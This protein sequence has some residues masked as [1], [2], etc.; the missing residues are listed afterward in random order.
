MKNPL[1]NGNNGRDEKGRFA[2]G[3]KKG[4][5]NPYALRTAQMRRAMLNAVSDEDLHEIVTNLISQAKQGDTQAFNV[6]FDRLF[7]KPIPAT[8]LDRVFLEESTLARM[9]R[10]GAPTNTEHLVE[11]MDFKIPAPAGKTVWLP[12]Q[13][14]FYVVGLNGRWKILC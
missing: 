9:I 13:G 5:G 6:L 10:A 11:D 7:G 12:Q 14:R 2:I 3:N 4:P 1:T 8:V